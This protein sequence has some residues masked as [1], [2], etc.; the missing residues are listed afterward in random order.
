MNG[1]FGKNYGD[2]NISDSLIYFKNVVIMNEKQRLIHLIFRV[3]C[4][5]IIKVRQGTELIPSKDNIFFKGVV[6]YELFG[7]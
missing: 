5:I 1:I 2:N 3:L 7:N 6:Y 4:D